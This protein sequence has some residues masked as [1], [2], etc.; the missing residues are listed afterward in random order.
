MLPCETHPPGRSWQWQEALVLYNQQVP[1]ACQGSH[2]PPLPEALLSL[3]L[4]PHWLIHV[5]TSYW[6]GH[7]CGFHCTHWL[8]DLL[9]HNVKCGLLSRRPY[10]QPNA[11]IASQYLPHLYQDTVIFLVLGSLVQRDYFHRSSS[12][13]KS[14]KDVNETW[15]SSCRWYISPLSSN[16]QALLQLKTDFNRVQVINIHN[17]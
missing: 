16:C 13:H 15:F 8:S 14:F 11:I 17:A 5:T 7:K 3:D 10:N 1:R 6:V 2:I 9:D 12:Y 4:Q